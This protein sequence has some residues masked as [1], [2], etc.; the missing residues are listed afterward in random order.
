MAMIKCSRL[1]DGVF[2]LDMLIDRGGVLQLHLCR[3]E[4]RVLISFNSYLS[5]RKSDEGDVLKT[6]EEIDSVSKLGGMLYE[7]ENSDY[8][9]WFLDQSYGIRSG[10][11]QYLVLTSNDVVEV[12]C[13][14]NPDVE[15]MSELP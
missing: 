12:I 11:K 6:L 15:F 4:E 3:R 9:Q 5:Y 7:I 1:I 14:E 13:L 2:L 8:L 10:A